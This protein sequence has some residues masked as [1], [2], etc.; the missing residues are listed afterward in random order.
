MGIVGWLLKKGVE[1]DEGEFVECILAD[2]GFDPFGWNGVWMSEEGEAGVCEVKECCVGCGVGGKGS[3]VVVAVLDGD[4]EDVPWVGVV[5][6]V[7]GGWKAKAEK[8]VDE[9]VFEDGGVN[10]GEGVRG[11]GEWDCEE[12]SGVFTLVGDG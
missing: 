3:G 2:R 4:M 8:K 11:G 9:E 12:R 1:E 5:V 6:G 7:V 10:S